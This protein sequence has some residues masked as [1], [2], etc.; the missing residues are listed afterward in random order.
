MNFAKSNRS[1]HDRAF[2]GTFPL[3][4]STGES[5]EATRCRRETQTTTT[6]M[7]MLDDDLDPA[8]VR[9]PD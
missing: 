4:W 1:R 2:P 3:G 9:E 7:M 5:S 8:V 6:T